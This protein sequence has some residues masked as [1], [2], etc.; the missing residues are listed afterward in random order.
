M[1]DDDVPDGR[2][3]GWYIIISPIE[4][5]QADQVFS[6]HLWSFHCKP[7]LPRLP[8]KLAKQARLV[9][10]ASGWHVSSLYQVGVEDLFTRY[11]DGN[12]C[13]RCS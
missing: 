10:L 4:M 9:I 6:G 13:G 8:S 11:S 2:M 7:G 1:T 12:Y 3:I 5:P